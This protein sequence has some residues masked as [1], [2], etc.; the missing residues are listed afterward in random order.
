MFRPQTWR[1][2]PTLLLVLLV[3]ALAMLGLQLRTKQ[4]HLRDLTF[5]KRRLALDLQVL[6]YLPL[7]TVDSMRD[8]IVG[9]KDSTVGQSAALD[10][11]IRHSKDLLSHRDAIKAQVDGYCGLVQERL[12]NRAKIFAGMV[13][14]E[15]KAMKDIQLE[16]N[17]RRD[18]IE[19]I[20]A[21]KAE[22]EKEI[23][24]LQRMRDNLQEEV[25][26][27]TQRVEHAAELLK[28]E[29][30]ITQGKKDLEGVDSSA[31]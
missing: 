26:E 7:K 4:V 16:L 24:R 22:M 18:Q 9:G 2:M 25:K 3:S 23:G 27:E 30:D 17:V 31:Q 5:Q 15:G 19:D 12:D 21:K 29:K 11:A 20:E 8:V 1:L 6:E 10:L 13:E 28:N 14:R